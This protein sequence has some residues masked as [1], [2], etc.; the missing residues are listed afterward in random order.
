MLRIRDLQ[1]PIFIKTYSYK[2][3]ILV[4][5]FVYLTFALFFFSLRLN[6][7]PS[8]R[9]CLQSNVLPTRWINYHSHKQPTLSTNLSAINLNPMPVN[10][11]H[12]DAATKRIYSPRCARNVAWYSLLCA[13]RATRRREAVLRGLRLV[14]LSRTARTLSLPDCF[15]NWRGPISQLGG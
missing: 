12:L 7:T 14:S 2:S 10:S 9:Y 11:L 4:R 13:T 6:S 3:M 8:I 15:L 5:F 1:E